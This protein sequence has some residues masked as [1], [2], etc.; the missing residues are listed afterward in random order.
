MTSLQDF[1]AHLD[2]AWAGTG[3]VHPS[4]WSRGGPMDVDMTWQRLLPSSTVIVR[5]AHRLGTEPAFESVTMLS[6]AEP[7]RVWVFDTLGFLPDAPGHATL[8][9][10]ELT[11]VRQSPRGTNLT[12]YGLQEDTRTLVVRVSFVAAGAGAAPTTVAEARL[13]RRG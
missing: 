11:L 9:G 2:G 12:S 10:H 7:A 3:L 4:P 13:G 8:A 1:C 5:Y 6:L